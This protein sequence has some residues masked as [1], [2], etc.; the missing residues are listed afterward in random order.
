M[1]LLS[2]ANLCISVYVTLRH[3]KRKCKLVTDFSFHLSLNAKFSF[4]ILQVCVCVYREAETQG[5]RI[6]K[7]NPHVSSCTTVTVIDTASSSGQ[8]QSRRPSGGVTHCLKLSSC[9]YYLA[10]T[11]SVSIFGNSTL[12]S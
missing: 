8:S 2:I 1:I 9:Y 10:Q 4:F 6:L 11:F 7:P 12:E 5:S 3:L